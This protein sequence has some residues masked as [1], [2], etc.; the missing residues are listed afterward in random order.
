MASN[1]YDTDPFEVVSKV[2]CLGTKDQY[3]VPDKITAKEIFDLDPKVI[4]KYF[5]AVVSSIIEKRRTKYSDTPD[6]LLEYSTQ[7][8][9]VSV[10]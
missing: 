10:K 6:T 2:D 3:I 8:E 5:F 7:F 4:Q 9:Q 1:Y